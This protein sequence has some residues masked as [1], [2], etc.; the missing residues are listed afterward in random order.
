VGTHVPQCERRLEPH[1]RLRPAELLEPRRQRTSLL[2]SGRL[3][4]SGGREPC[5]QRDSEA[6]PGHHCSVIHE[7]RETPTRLLALFMLLRLGQQLAEHLLARANRR[8]GLDPERQRWAAQ[9]L[10]L[11]DED[12]RRSVAYATDRYRFGRVWDWARCAAVLAFLAAAGLGWAESLA[13][14][15]A[16]RLRLGSVGAGLLFFAILGAGSALAALPFALHATFRIEQRHGFNRQTL[17]GFLL[18]RLK[19]LL[20][21]ALLGGPLLAALLALIERAGP[22]WW[23]AAWLVTSGFSVLTAWVYPTLLAPIFNR[24]TPLPPG[25]LRQR[26]DALTERT[27]FRSRGVF[28]MDAS[29]RTTH[30]NAY[31]TG[32]GGARRIVLFDTLLE[33]L[34]PPQ[35]VAVLAHEL[36]HFKLRHVRSRL[37]LGLGASALLF[38][39]LSLGLPLTA[40]YTAFGLAGPS[41]YGALAVFGLWFGLLDFLLRPLERALLRRH[42]RAADAFA[43]RHATAHDLAAALLALR[44]RSRSLPLCHPAYSRVYLS[45]PPLLERLKAIGALPEN[46]LDPQA[47][48]ESESSARGGRP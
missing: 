24:F 34:E 10:G 5:E 6:A 1:L 27:G 20:L 14:V 43:A 46:R 22:R 31:F 39:A 16:S 26:I 32:M 29:R 42:E 40:F 7:V 37:L 21:S 19:E 12:L 2:S 44:E 38:Y 35:V 48:A 25:D 41:A 23:L 13:G 4:R 3:G 8:Y 47:P 45:H 18:D 17:R 30:G 11:S 9:T 36:G 15:L 33:A 28:V